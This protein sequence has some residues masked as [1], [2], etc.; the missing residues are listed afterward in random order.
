MNILAFLPILSL[1]MFVHELGHFV[2]AAT[3]TITS[4]AASATG[5]TRRRWRGFT[6]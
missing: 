5:M 2:T 6:L 4:S 3:T 1:M